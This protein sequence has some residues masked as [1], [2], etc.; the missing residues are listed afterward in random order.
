V[1]LHELDGKGNPPANS[2]TV[3]HGAKDHDD[4]QTRYKSAWRRHARCVWPGARRNRRAIQ[5]W[6]S[7]TRI[8]RVLRAS[9][10]FAK[11]FPDRFHQC[12]DSVR[13]TWSAWRVAWREAGSSRSS[14]ASLLPHLPRVRPVPDG[15]RLSADECEGGRLARRHSV[16]EDG[17]SQQS[18]E[19]IAFDDLR[20]PTLS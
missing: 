2:C 3:K 17:V 15:G 18:I 19:D 16:G 8:S 13:P 10:G 9:A 20:S 6:S 11:E 7:S 12:R 5:K 1:A 14:T 4:L